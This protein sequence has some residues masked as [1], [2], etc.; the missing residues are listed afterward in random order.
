MVKKFCFIFSF[1]NGAIIMSFASLI[2]GIALI[3]ECVVELKG[4]ESSKKYN[5]FVVIGIIMGLTSLLAGGVLAASVIQ[6]KERYILLYMLLES[7][8]LLIVSIYSGMFVFTNAA[9]L[10]LIMICG[11]LWLGIYGLY[12]FYLEIAEYNLAKPGV[13]EISYT[14]NA[15]YATSPSGQVENTA[16]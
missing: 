4:G 16:V 12:G 3:L 7:V 8:L 13:Y 10:F 2:T 15:A 1:R 6:A 5:S 9:F 11:L 14:D